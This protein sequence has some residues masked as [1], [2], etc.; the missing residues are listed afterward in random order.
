MLFKTIKQLLIILALSSILFTFQIFAQESKSSYRVAI[1]KTS[2]PYHFVDSAGKPSGLMVDMWRLWATKQGV[3]VSFVPLNWEQTIAQVKDSDVDIHA[4]LSKNAKR[5]QILAF[6]DVFFEQNRHLFLHRSIANIRHIEQLTPYAIGVV[7]GSSHQTSI[8]QKFP[9]LTVRKFANR[10]A[11]YNAALKNEILIIA[12]VEKLS[13][14]YDNYALLNQNFPAFARIPYHSS[15][16][17]TAVAKNNTQLLAFVQQGIDKITAKE[18]SNIERKWL[19]IDK[20]DNLINLSFSGMKA[21]FSD[22]SVT[23]NAQGFFI[24]L[25]RQ[26]AQFNG[27]E[28]D[29]LLDDSAEL[30]LLNQGLADI[31]L[32]NVN[33][34]Q[35][36]DNLLLGPVIYSVDYGLFLSSNIEQ[37]AHVSELRNKTIGVL[38][39][40]EFIENIKENVEQVTIVAYSDYASL[41]QA[42]E[43]GEFDIIAGQKDLIEH[44]LVENNLQ[45][46]FSY[47]NGYKFT[48]NINAI[49]SQSQPELA[50]LIQQGFD[51]IPLE[52]LVALEKR[53]Q[54]DKSSGFYKRQ[55]A[56]LKLDDVEAAWLKERGSI[57]FGITKSWLPVEFVDNYGD[58]RGINV[59]IFE[60]ISQRL[61]V[62]IN[63]SAYNNFEEL[64]QALLNG[65]V[66]AVGSVM[67]TKERRE[68]V[69]FTDSYWSMPWVIVHPRELGNQLSLD[70]FKGKSLAI[71]K[72]YYLVSVIRNEF[73]TISLK[74]VDETE[75]GLLA[76]QKGMVDGYIDSLSSG[77][78]LLR[79]ESMISLG[80]SV[81]DEVD[82]NG[83]HIAVNNNLP[84]LANV[85]NKAVLTITDMESQQIYEKWFDISIETGLD[86]NVVVRVAAQVG[87]LIVIIIIIIMVWNRRL[88]LEIKNRKRLEQQ[89]KYM[90]THDDLTGLA[91]RILLKDR[92]NKAI[93]F[94]QR[95]QLSIAVLFI[96]LDGFKNI[97]DNYGHDVGD[98]LLIEVAKR[99]NACVRDSDTVVR[100]GGDE[101]VLLLTG[102][103]NQDEAAYVAEKVLKIIQQ[104]IEL[105]ADIKAIIGSSIGIAMYPDDGDSDNDLLKVA[106]S[107]MYKVKASG[108]NHYVFNHKAS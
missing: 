8:E 71:T 69:L 2:Y 73:P 89:M 81:L 17:S 107:L 64:Y 92:L 38:S 43:Q 50:Q 53:W 79:R 76:V 78:E 88:Y 67:A 13:K 75:E 96:D 37:I 68:Q 42:A 22:I 20:S 72:G 58:Y 80:M 99:L 44:Y 62:D 23:G 25:W 21:P 12:G 35:K 83:N 54:L 14:N 27:L 51:E 106:D 1:N 30:N 98:E 10:H 104:P 65:E 52:N 49:L 3:D 46:S 61:N 63:Y 66:D 6:S 4:G 31:H 85:L 100:F 90:A 48:R 59:D 28:V 94:H 36:N 40:D 108:K 18:K 86:K 55:L 84:I 101:F 57:K 77:T 16:Y 34:F 32:D 105:S 91:N 93:A 7:E 70:D 19:G 95:Q 5:E 56:M 103:H 45:S 102:L 97:N 29:F 15:S 60:L 33:D 47:F 74:L 87:V 9:F 39:N 26:W 41:F 11:L 82:R 24:E